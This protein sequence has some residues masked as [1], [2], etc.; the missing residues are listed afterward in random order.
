MSLGKIRAGTAIA[1][2][3]AGVTAL[4]ACSSSGSSSG[5]TSGG[6][7]PP[8]GYGSVPAAASGTQHAGTITYALQ[9]G[10]TPNSIFP[11]S[12]TATNTV[13]N[14][15]AFGWKMWRPLYWT[16]N[17]VT[18]EVVPSMSL[19]NLPTF[20]NGNKTVTITMKSNFKWSDGQP[21]TSK[22]L[23]FD[24]D[25]IKAGGQGE[26][27]ELGLL[28]AGA[29]PGRLDQRLH[30][31]LVHAGAEP[32]RAGQPGLVHRRHP[33]LRRPDRPAPVAGLGQGLGERPDP[34]LHQPGQRHEDLQLPDRAE[35]VG[36]HLRQ[37]P[38]VAGGG[39]PVQ[40][41][42]VQRHHRRVH[43]GAE[44][45]LRRPARGEDVGLPGR[46]VHLDRRRAQRGEGGLDRRRPDPA[47]PDPAGPGGQAARLQR[48]RYP[49]LRHGVRQLQLQGH[50]GQLR[51]DREPAVLPAGHG[52]PAGRAGLHHRVHA[53]R[54]RPGLRAHPGLPAEPL[55]ALQRG[56]QPVPVQ[57]L[58]PR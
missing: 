6:S 22:D 47:G 42:R 43:D 10:A 15:E 8:G 9:P 20:S 48:V 33:V 29:L 17:G 51:R 4:A 3:T 38:A 31:E 45:Q 11:I 28:R 21:V 58:Q 12:T 18:P 14:V 16:Q 26:P 32:V 54:G 44:H 5:G 46:A 30:A 24:L 25:L 39:R 34:G 50:H 27:L 49:G 56:D 23:L 1:V 19:A 55:S 40:A 7:T 41:E 37:Q 57:R 13:Y 35:Q 2:L 52:P 36:E 53:R